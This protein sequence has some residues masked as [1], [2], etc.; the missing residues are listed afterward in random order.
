MQ[1]F[2]YNFGNAVWR[3]KLSYLQAWIQAHVEDAA[4]LGKR[5]FSPTLQRPIANAHR[6]PSQHW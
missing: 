4:D 3:E 1:A 5:A 2:D 6:R